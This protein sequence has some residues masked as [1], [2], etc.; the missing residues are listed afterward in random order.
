MLKRLSLFFFGFLNIL[1]FS[2]CSL[3]KEQLVNDQAAGCVQ[4]FYLYP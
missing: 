3:V 2:F 4:L 1:T